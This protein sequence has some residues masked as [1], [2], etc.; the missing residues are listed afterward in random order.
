MRT[1]MAK[2]SPKLYRNPLGE[3]WTKEQVKLDEV[4]TNFT[5]RPRSKEKVK[6]LRLP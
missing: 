5:I 3:S 1:D 4:T 6:K 2:K